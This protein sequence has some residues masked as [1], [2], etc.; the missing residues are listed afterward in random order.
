L[1][2]GEDVVP[3][4]AGGGV[5]EGV[6]APVGIAAGEAAESFFDVAGDVGFVGPLVAVGAED[7]AA[8]EVVEED[9]FVDELVMVGGDFAAE[10]AEIGIALG[11]RSI[12]PKT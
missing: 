6:A 8:V 4:E 10:D 11:L 3:D 9:E 2:V 5:G 1:L 12:S 7:A